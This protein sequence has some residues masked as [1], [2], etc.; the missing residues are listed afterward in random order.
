MRGKKSKNSESKPDIP[1]VKMQLPDKDE[2]VNSMMNKVKSNQKINPNEGFKT[3]FLML[4]SQD[5]E[6]R[7]SALE[8]EL[9]EIKEN[10]A[11]KNE[12]IKVLESKFRTRSRKLQNFHN[13]QKFRA[14][15]QLKKWKRIKG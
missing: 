3:L 14:S 13:Y 8:V 1:I 9:K 7:I 12:K 15:F 11:E 4:F 2:L 10:L 6:E 5:Y